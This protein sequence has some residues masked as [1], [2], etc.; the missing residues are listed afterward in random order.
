MQEN[1]VQKSVINWIRQCRIIATIMN[2]VIRIITI[3]FYQQL[4]HIKVL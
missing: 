4:Q 3:N 1:F 2:I